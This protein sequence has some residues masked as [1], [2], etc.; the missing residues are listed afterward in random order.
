MMEHFA[1][2]MEPGLT[3]VRRAEK[4][5]VRIPAV[6]LVRLV[7]MGMAIVYSSARSWGDDVLEVPNSAKRMYCLLLLT[8]ELTRRFRS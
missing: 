3:V 2:R 5:V 6:N 8:A 7:A 1:A 4:S